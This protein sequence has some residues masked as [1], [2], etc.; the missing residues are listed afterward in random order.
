MLSI[1]VAI[2]EAIATNSAL[3]LK[4]ALTILAPLILVVAIATKII[5]SAG[6]VVVVRYRV[7]GKETI[8]N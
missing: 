7:A 4:L 6:E 2:A 1:R 8:R 3:V 5:R